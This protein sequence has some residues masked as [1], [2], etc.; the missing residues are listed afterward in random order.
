LNRCAGRE[1]FTQL[2]KYLNTKEQPEI[3]AGKIE[4]L[5]KAIVVLQEQLAE[6]RLITNTISEENVRDSEQS[7]QF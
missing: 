2:K 6:Q 1:K 5:K 4:P 7:F 3:E